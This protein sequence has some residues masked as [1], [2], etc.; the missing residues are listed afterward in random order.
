MDHEPSCLKFIC[1]CQPCEVCKTL[2]KDCPYCE[3]DLRQEEP[4]ENTHQPL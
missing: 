3:E 2:D 1:T 4:R